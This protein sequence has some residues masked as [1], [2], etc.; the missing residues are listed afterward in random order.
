MDTVPLARSL[1][2]SLINF[3]A[4]VTSMRPA[5]TATTIN[6]LNDDDRPFHALRVRACITTPCSNF[7]AEIWIQ[8]HSECLSKL[9]RPD[10]SAFNLLSSY[11]EKL[12]AIR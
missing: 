9:L 3:A 8:L 4:C 10:N 12:H 5:D 11:T 2:R 6:L 7:M 1:V